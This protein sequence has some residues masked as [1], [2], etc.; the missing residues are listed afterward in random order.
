MIYLYET[1]VLF[2]LCKGNTQQVNQIYSVN[3]SGYLNSINGK[4]QQSPSVSST[5]LNSSGTNNSPYQQQ[6]NQQQM[7]PTFTPSPILYMTPMAP[8]DYGYPDDMLD[9]GRSDN[10]HPPSPSN[11]SCMNSPVFSDDGTVPDVLISDL[12]VIYGTSTFQ[13]TR[14]YME[15][16]HK[17]KTELD[18]NPSISLFG[19]FD[20]HGGDKCANFVKK[21]I[22]QITNKFIK[23][24]KTCY[25]SK[26]TGSAKSPGMYESPHWKKSSSL[27]RNEQQN[28]TQ[29]RSD[30]LQ[31]ALYN[32]FMTLDSRYSK[33]YRSKNESGTTSLVALLS[34][35]P[36]A[37][38]L[39]V[40]ANAGDSRGVLCRSGK[41]V[42][43]SFDH[44]PGNPKEKQRITTS[45]GKIDWDY[46]ERIWRVAGILSVSRGI[47]DIPL[48]KWVIPDP[49]FVVIPLKGVTKCYSRSNRGGSQGCSPSRMFSSPLSSRNSSPFRGSPKRTQSSLLFGKNRTSSPQ[50]F[51][52]MPTDEDTPMSINNSMSDSP[53]DSQVVPPPL[54]LNN[55]KIHQ[56]PASKRYSQQFN[57]ISSFSNRSSSLRKMNYNPLSSSLGAGNVNQMTTPAPQEIDQYFVLATDGIW[58]VFSNQELVDYI[59]KLIEDYYVS[60]QLDWDP[61]DIA[62][63]VSMEAFTRGSGDNSTVIIVKLNWK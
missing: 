38:P 9:D 37:P 3:S 50:G 52:L 16:R 22:T 13:G 15:D 30:L 59:N 11:L 8:I 4:E 57:S 45:G 18:N 12:E 31:T 25:S 36:N 62:K 28:E 63:R 48:K 32:T 40:V 44:K 51:G 49:E 7:V 41:A 1:Q 58:D 2:T 23:E 35:P 10:Q 14:R 56:Q 24:N 61:Y 39:L 17:I 33:K 43:L 26:N 54:I 6:P 5:S 55:I 60:K 34:T 47:G 19:V 46:N 27:S 21:R 42:A 53:Q 20:G 29:N